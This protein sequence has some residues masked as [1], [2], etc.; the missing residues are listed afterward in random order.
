MMKYNYEIQFQ[1]LFLV[2]FYGFQNF[3]VFQNGRHDVRVSS[4]I[5]KL[6]R[7]P[8]HLGET[9]FGKFHQN[10]P[11]SFA[12]RLWTDRHTHTHRQTH[13]HTHTDNPGIFPRNDHNTFRQ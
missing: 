11:S 5:S 13:R 1:G 4:N 12:K 7:T 9:I 8:L 3:P 6:K 2:R 10:R